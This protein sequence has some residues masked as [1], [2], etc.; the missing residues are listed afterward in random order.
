MNIIRGKNKMLMTDPVTPQ[1]AIS[2]KSHIQLVVG[3]TRC[4]PQKATH[5]AMLTTT[6]RIMVG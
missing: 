5:I 2:I 3:N 1:M 4:R 6:Y